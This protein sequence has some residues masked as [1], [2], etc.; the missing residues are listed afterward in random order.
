[1][2]KN[3]KKI[4]LHLGCG[5][6]IIREENVEWINIDVQDIPGVDKVMGIYPL[7]IKSNS[8][9]VVYS[10]SVLEHLEE[11]KLTVLKDWVRVLKPNGVLRVSVPDFSKAAELYLK[12]KDVDLIKGWVLG[13]ADKRVHCHSI[14][15]DYK[16]LKGLMEEAGLE[17]I[18]YWDP[19]RQSHRDFFDMSQALTC[20]MQMSLNLEGFKKIK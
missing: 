19:R 17:A 9:D 6:V 13:R 1:M 18:H 7:K 10:S 5:N 2:Q 11:D 20:D 4:K 16:K 3:K 12:E 14:L 15:F 8:I